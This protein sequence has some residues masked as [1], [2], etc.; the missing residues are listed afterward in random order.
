MNPRA[1]CVGGITDPF[2]FFIPPGPIPARFF[3]FQTAV[4]IAPYKIIK[5]FSL[6]VLA[7]DERWRYIISV[8]AVRPPETGV[9]HLMEQGLAEPAR[10][11][12]K[13]RNQAEMLEMNSQQHKKMPSGIGSSASGFPGHSICGLRIR[14][15]PFLFASGSEEIVSP[16][17]TGTDSLSV[18]DSH[19]HTVRFVSCS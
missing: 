8:K 18:P 17:H 4:A 19:S 2:S 9:D 7:F 15:K 5:S 12:N 13:K 3:I 16:L 11:G 1:R 10:S 6:F 14:V